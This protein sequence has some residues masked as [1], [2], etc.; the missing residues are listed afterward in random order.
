MHLMC[1]CTCKIIEILFVNDMHNFENGIQNF[2]TGLSF[3]LGL[4]K[5]HVV[6]TFVYFI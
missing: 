3:E 2:E 1:M 5:K 6:L 4:V